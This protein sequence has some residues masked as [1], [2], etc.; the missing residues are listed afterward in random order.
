MALDELARPRPPH[1]LL[2]APV[3][4][5]ALEE[6]VAL[7]V[8]RVVTGR[9]VGRIEVGDG[10][11]GGIE[12]EDL[13]AHARA[14]LARA[15]EDR[16]VDVAHGLAEQLA[17]AHP[18]LASPVVVAQRRDGEHPAGLLARRGEAQRADRQRAPRGVHVVEVRP[19]G[20]EE[21]VVRGG[22]VQPV[23][24]ALDEVAPVAVRGAQQVHVVRR[25]HDVVVRDHRLRERRGEREMVVGQ[26]LAAG[27]LQRVRDD[28]AARERVH[29]RPGRQRREHARPGAARGGAWSP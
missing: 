9:R 8:A 16:R 14:R 26:H 11:A 29:G 4:R 20:V 25:Q 27:R 7:D 17:E 23:E 1:D 13:A 19:R 22:E 21:R 5:E 24:R 15:R 18:Q 10:H 2:T 12:V 28:P 6:V 3:R